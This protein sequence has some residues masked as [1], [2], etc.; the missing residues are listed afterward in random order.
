MADKQ[1]RGVTRRALFKGAGAA[2]A[3]GALF[4]TVDGRADESGAGPV[5]QGPGK[6]TVTLR[7]NGKERK[8]EVEPRDT[9]LDTLRL[10][11]DL[12][13]AKPVCERSTCGACTVWLDGAPVYAC[14]VLTVEAE[15]RDV[16]TV[17]GLG[18][19]DAMHA[20]QAAF[21]EHDAMQCGFCTPGMVMSCA[22]AVK[23]HGK[24]LTEAQAREACSGQPLPLRHLSARAQGRARRGEGG[25]SHA[26]HGHL[27]GRASIGHDE[28]VEG[29]RGR[30]PA[31]SPSRST[32]RTQSPGAVRQD[33]SSIVG[34]D[35]AA[36]GRAGQGQRAPRSTPTTSTGRTWPSPGCVTAPHAHARMKQD[37][38][39]RGARG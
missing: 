6:V 34:K 5:S 15:G 21:V 22:A 27:Q 14:S 29:R 35:S 36:R 30:P 33:A 38:R 24:D 9:L 18:S 12:T 16:T 23:E 10:P 28:Y 1:R 8:V 3:A 19:P 31:R 4:R 26:A 32:S 7:C 17:E 20:V 39:R 37:R 25:L 11:L 2:A 13:G